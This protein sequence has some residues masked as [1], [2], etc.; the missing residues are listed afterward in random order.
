MPIKLPQIP[1]SRINGSA[2]RA[3]SM[4]AD[5]R[6]GQYALRFAFSQQLG[7]DELATLPEAD[8]APMPADARPVAGRPPR[9]GDTTRLDP[10]APPMSWPRS[11]AAHQARYRT[12]QVTPRQ[13]AET[14]LRDARA[15]AARLGGAPICMYDDEVALR[16]ADESTARWK[17]G[18]PL[19]PLDGVMM[20][21]KEQTAMTGLPV[22]AGTAFLHLEPAAADAT[23]VARL[24]AAG[25][26]LLGSSPMTEYGMS[27]LGLNPQRAMP[28]NPHRE[29]RV[30]GGSSTGSGVAVAVGLCP[31]AVANDGGG[32]IRIPSSLSGVFGIKPTFGRISRAGDTYRGTMATMGPIGS[33]TTDLA[34][35][36]DV[37]AGPDE[38]DSTTTW[39]PARVPGEFSAALG[40][41]AK[42]L[43][44][45]VYDAAF[46]D[47]QPAVAQSCRA[48]LSLLERAGA[49]LVPVAL[50]LGRFSPAI[51]Y[52]TIGLEAL[53]AMQVARRKHKELIGRD[54]YTSMATLDAFGATDYI[55]A[56]CLRAR[57][58]EQTA[59][60]FRDVDLLA[61]P[62][63]ATT[64]PAFT[65]EDARGGLLD[66]A[67][68]HGVCRTNMLGNLTGLPGASVPVGRDADSLP[69]GLQLMGDAWDEA[70]IL[71]AAAQLERDGAATAIRPRD[72]VP[73]IQGW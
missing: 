38:M 17:A 65:E 10:P 56:Q 14:A 24:R 12:G 16:A 63:T 9:G 58:R 45:G 3:V 47:S 28:R 59:A 61:L 26:I 31:V 57:L 46:A 8:R 48:A 68:L 60:L 6:A 15:I 49:V 69:I 51:G 66:A 37:C 25:A 50:P 67:A 21:V 44:I 19:G 20:V 1:A 72:S 36:L 22:R 29:G 71:A 11:G 4:L 43:R 34:S 52:L 53:A 13:V 23:C 55:D 42:G 64:A 41:G 33:S 7:I 18:K 35:F 30:A 27:P 40:R 70:S 39:A 2:L 62:A 5:T 73:G 32:S 54:F